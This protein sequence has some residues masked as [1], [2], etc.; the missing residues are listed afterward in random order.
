MTKTQKKTLEDLIYSEIVES[1][2]TDNPGFISLIKMA[3]EQSLFFP[4]LYT[5]FFILG[6]NKSFFWE[7]D[8]VLENY[9]TF[10]LDVKKAG[11]IYVDISFQQI[12]SFITYIIKKEGFNTNATQ[13]LTTKFI[14]ACRYGVI[15]PDSF[16]YNKT[17]QET[18]T[19]DYILQI[20]HFNKE[21]LSYCLNNQLSTKPQTQELTKI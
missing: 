19:E 8:Q 12:P 16:F 4:Q 18:L 21:N 11:S 2:K 13:V 17:I 5:T 1:I 9:S 15:L 20:N 7:K 3:Q 14:E 10:G 6:L